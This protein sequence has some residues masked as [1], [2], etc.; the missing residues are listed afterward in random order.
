MLDTAG[1]DACWANGCSPSTPGAVPEGCAPCTLDCYATESTA[2]NFI[3]L[4]TMPWS[5]HGNTLYV[6]YQKGEQIL[7]D[8]NFTKVDFVE[9]FDA[10]Q[11]G[12]LM[13]NL[14]SNTAGALSPPTRSCWRE[15]CIKDDEICIKD[16]EFCIKDDEFCI[17]RWFTC[18]GASCP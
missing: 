15:F 3:A 7:A 17:K 11:D 6:E 16:D 9:R 13:K 10:A 2:N 18:A 12:W 1:N 14:Y 8:I 5:K 4:R